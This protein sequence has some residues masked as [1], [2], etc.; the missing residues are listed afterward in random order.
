M[1]YA[2]LILPSLP[3]LSPGVGVSTPQACARAARPLP[4]G[5]SAPPGKNGGEQTLCQWPGGDTGT[6]AQLGSSLHSAAGR[7][8]P[9]WGCGSYKQRLVSVVYCMG[10]CRGAGV[11]LAGWASWA[12]KG[13]GLT[14]GPPLLHLGP[15]RAL[16]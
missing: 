5:P 16:S 3:S 15:F 11:G 14:P 12:Q 2:V 4:S 8:L 7:A 1:Q 9:V 10:P 13:T 6:C